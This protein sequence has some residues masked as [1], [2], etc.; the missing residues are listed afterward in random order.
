MK[1]KELGR[2]QK[3]KNVIT[4]DLILKNMTR[5]T[6]QISM[7]KVKQKMKQEER[8]MNTKWA[9]EVCVCVCIGDK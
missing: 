5:K 4:P 2:W 8:N 1:W 3:K 7:R 6:K 9:M